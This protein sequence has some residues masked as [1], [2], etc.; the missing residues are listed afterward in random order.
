[1]AL[2]EDGASRIRR[3][4][5]KQVPAEL[6]DRVR[7]EHRVRGRAVTIVEYQAPWNPEPSSWW[8]EVPQARIKY[9]EQ[10]LGWT[11]YW[12]DRNS[13]AHRYDLVE[14]HQPIERLSAECDEDPTGIFK[15]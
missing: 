3:F 2:P 6:L 7:V 14:P 11:L 8:I 10:T 9:D 15:G 13:R 12:F 1:M 4:C 5:E